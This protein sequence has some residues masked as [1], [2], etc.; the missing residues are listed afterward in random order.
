[1]TKEERLHGNRIIG[2]FMGRSF[3]MS[4]ISDYKGLPDNELPPMRYHCDYRW[5]MP[6]WC[7]FRDKTFKKEIHWF[8]HSDLKGIISRALCYE[9]ILVAFE[10]LIEGIKWYNETLCA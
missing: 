6:A 4:H 5:L 9:D 10:K 7:A 2:E 3:Q 1:M 8:R